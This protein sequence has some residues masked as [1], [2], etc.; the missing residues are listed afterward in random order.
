MLI[1]GRSL[2]ALYA[3]VTYGKAKT[4]SCI[5]GSI[6]DF[7]WLGFVMKDFNMHQ[8]AEIARIENGIFQMYYPAASATYFL[9]ALAVTLYVLPK[10][11]RQA[12]LL[13]VFSSGAILGLIAV[14][15]Y[16]GSWSEDRYKRKLAEFRSTL[17]QDQVKTLG[18]P[19]FARFNSPFQLWFLRRNEIWLEVVH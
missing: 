4:V 16:S 10:V 18:E 6:C 2:I 7:L 19:I 17:E 13:K 15:S 3:K 11:T 5:F 12:S 14:F 8:L 9:M 1:I